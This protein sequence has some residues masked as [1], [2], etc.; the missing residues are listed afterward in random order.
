MGSSVSW[1]ILPGPATFQCC[2]KILRQDCCHRRH[3]FKAFCP[4]IQVLWYHCLLIIIHNNNNNN[5]IITLTIL[6]NITITL[7]NNIPYTM[8]LPNITEFIKLWRQ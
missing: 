4:R 2:P 5:S 6:N 1:L 3:L 7:N 8:A